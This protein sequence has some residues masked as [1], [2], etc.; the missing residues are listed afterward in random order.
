MSSNLESGV[1]LEIVVSADLAKVPTPLTPKN[2]VDWKYQV[3]I[4]LTT[5]HV[6]D[7]FIEKDEN[8]NRQEPPEDATE[9]RRWNELKVSTSSNISRRSL[10]PSRTTSHGPRTK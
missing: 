1:N 5:G 8:G 3:E 2:V 7:K 4:A 6:F 9:L 10:L